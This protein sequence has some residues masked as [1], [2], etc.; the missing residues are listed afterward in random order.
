MCAKAS[1]Q[2]EAVG[3]CIVCGMGLCMEHAI[4]DDTVLT[5]CWLR[6]A[7]TSGLTPRSRSGFRGFCAWSASKLWSSPGN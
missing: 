7:K 4:R 6:R 5:Q 2:T 3:I 1:K